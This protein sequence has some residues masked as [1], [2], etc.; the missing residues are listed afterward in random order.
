MTTKE[1]RESVTSATWRTLA[2]ALDLED[3]FQAGIFPSGSGQWQHFRRL[4]AAGLLAEE[5]YGNDIDGDIDQ[6]V[7]VFR[8]TPEGRSLASLLEKEA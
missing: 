4:V 3:R 8:L 6:E 1:A 5:G 2:R 7:L